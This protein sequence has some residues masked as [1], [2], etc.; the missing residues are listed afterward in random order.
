MK[1]WL[2]AG[3]LV[4]PL[5]AFAD[6][7]QTLPPIVVTA[8]RS[9]Q[10]DNRLPAALNVITRADIATSGAQTLADVLR[11]APG[12]QI[13]DFYGDGSAAEVDMRG[14]GDGSNATTL[15]LV[16]GRRLNNPD[17]GIPDLTSVPLKDIERI[18]IIQGSAGTLYGD[19][20]VGGVINIIT[21]APVS[22]AL[23]AR[24]Q[25]GGGSYGRQQAS[26]SVSQRF[27]GFSYRISGEGS[28]TD[29]YRDH[30]HLENENVLGRAGYDY[31]SGSAYLELGFVNNRLQTPGA[32][33]AA[34]EAQD[35]RQV[36]PD[37]AGD[38]SNTRTGLQR[39]NWRQDLATGWTLETDVTHRR[40]DG[41]FRL[42]FT[43]APATAD[44]TQQR[45]VWSINPR[46]EGGFALPAGRALLTLGADGQ[47]AEYQLL[48]PLGLQSNDQR[49]RDF[50][51]QAELPLWRTLEATVG[52]RNARVDNKV[53]Q[54]STSAFFVP[55]FTVPTPF[56]DTH[57][58]AELG[59]ALRPLDGLRLHARYDGNF[60]F[61]KVDEFTLTAAAPASGQNLLQTQTGGTYEFGSE[62]TRSAYS[63]GL[64]LYQL[65]LK[66]EIAFDPVSFTNVNL[67]R[68]R[69][70]G[71]V[72]DAGWQALDALKLSAAYQHLLATNGGSEDGKRIPLAARDSGKLAATLAL[73]HGATAYVEALA[74]GN[75]PYSGDYNNDL[76]NLPGYAV[77]N[78]ALNRQWRSWNFA[79]R[80]NNLLDHRYSENGVDS[81]DFPPPTF[82]A[83]PREA[84]YPSPGRNFWITASY[85]P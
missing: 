4:A 2:F 7:A 19:Q 13:D 53:M 63:L 70:S 50:Y 9:P 78:A 16:D 62:W 38:F 28:G 71:G 61:A 77:V 76:P 24:A 45:N 40:G 18:E 83:V 35:R 60:R 54:T 68:T 84:F 59:L 56:H 64:T 81:P 85:A 51:A 3:A 14:F 15:I 48:S 75:R 42:S 37:F 44:S 22:E 41:V 36:Q 31:G 52:V 10:P 57:T 67:A 11:T 1:A 80:V 27:G 8:T 30:N 43:G 5:A 21:R 74:V 72:L 58:A 39:L 46:V 12:V 32:L 20:A 33:F 73:P 66:N 25:I 17:I 29:N 34:Q 26:A 23:A 49:Q 69:R 47:L 82:T 65:R 6:D 79:A 55:V